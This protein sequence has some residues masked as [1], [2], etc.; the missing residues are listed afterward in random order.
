MPTALTTTQPIPSIAAPHLLTDLDLSTGELMALLELSSQVK[1]APEDYAEALKG[2]SIALL[3]EKPSLRT[4]MTFELAIQ[5]LGGH[6]IFQDHRDG[7]IGWIIGSSDRA[8]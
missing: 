1:A 8:V 7:R 2:C 3:F 4:R 5:Q 6:A